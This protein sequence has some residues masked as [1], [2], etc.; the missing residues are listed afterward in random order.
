MPMIGAY[1]KEL[2]ER[3]VN[4]PGGTDHLTFFLLRRESSVVV[5]KAWQKNGKKE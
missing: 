5:T 2:N 3:N 1:P 4:S